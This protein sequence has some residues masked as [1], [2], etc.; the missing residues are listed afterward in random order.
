[1]VILRIDRRTPG[2]WQW[3]HCLNHA[4]RGP[5][6]E[7]ASASASRRARPCGRPGNKHRPCRHLTSPEKIHFFFFMLMVIYLY[8]TRVGLGWAIGVSASLQCCYLRV[9]LQVLKKKIPG[10][11]AGSAAGETP[12]LVWYGSRVPAPDVR[13]TP[14]PQESRHVTRTCREKFVILSLL[15]L[16]SCYY[17]ISCL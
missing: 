17:D 14:R 8:C 11:A 1:V 5:R 2:Q 3:E 10:L 15:I 16:T 13:T 6:L 12:S 7:G 9:S 4:G